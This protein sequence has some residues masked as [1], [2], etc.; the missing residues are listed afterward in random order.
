MMKIYDISGNVLFNDVPL[1]SASELVQELMTADY[2]RLSWR[3]AEN[4][5]IPAGSYI[6]I[7]DERYTLL[8][9]YSPTQK[10]EG[11][12]EYTPEFKSPFFLNSK[13]PFFLYKTVGG[14]TYKEAEWSLT[15]LP[16]NFLAILCTT[17][18]NETGQKYTYAIGAD[19]AV[20]SATLAFNCTDIISAI[21]QIANAFETE[22]WLEKYDTPDNSG[23][24]GCLHLSR[25]QLDY[26]PVASRLRDSW[27]KFV[28]THTNHDKIIVS[29]GV[30]ESYVDSD[31]DS[32]ILEV[33]NN[34][35]VPTINQVLDYYNRFYVFGSSRN[36]PQDY[37]GAATNN[38]AVK[39]LTLNP[40]D[41]P[42]GYMDFSNG[43]PVFTKILQFDDIYP[44]AT[45]L[46][47]KDIIVRQRYRLDDENKKIQ[48]GTDE[49]GDPMYDIYNVYY[50][51]LKIYDEGSYT[52]FTFN[53]TDYDKDDN[54]TG[55]LLPG[56]PV[57]FHFTEGPLNGREFE[58][59]YHETA[60]SQPVQDPADVS[61]FSWR[62]GD[63]EIN[64]IEEGEF[65]IP[66]LTG[67]VPQE[68]NHLI[69]FN[70]HM[71]DEYIEDA[72]DRLEQAALD[73]INKNYLDTDT[74]EP[75]DNNTYT[76][77][78]DPTVFY[79]ADPSLVVGNKVLYKNGDYEK[80]TRITAIR[81]RLD[82]P[83]YQ[84]LTF[85]DEVKKGSIQQLKEE[86]VSTNKDIDLLK[87]I[88][89]STAEIT[90]AYERTHQLILKQMA[91]NVQHAEY[92]DE[93]GNAQK[94][95]NHIFSDYLNQAVKTSSEVAFAKVTAPD[96][97]SANFSSGNLG[98][99]FRLWLDQ[100]NDGELEL[101]RLI[102]RKVMKVY[103]LIIQQ[104]KFQGG[105]YIYSVG[106]IV[107]TEVEELANDG[108]YKCYFDTKEGQEPNPFVVGDQARC[109]RFN[110]GTT[111][112]KY[113]WRL[114]T[115]V[116][117]DYIVLSKTDK[118][119]DSG[120]PE[121]GDNIVQ[122]GHRSTASR[123]KGIVLT[124]IDSNA[125]RMDFYDDIDSYDL[126]GCLITTIG[127]KNG[128]VGVYTENGSFT[129]VVNVTGG[130][131]K[132]L[133]DGISLD[134]Q[135]TTITGGMVLSSFIGVKDTNNH[136]RAA[137]NAS[138]TLAP[139][140]P[141]SA[142][143]GTSADHGRL[144]IAAGIGATQADWEAAYTTAKTRIFEDGTLITNAL[145]A[146][147][148]RIARF[149]IT[150]DGLGYGSLSET[151]Y[152]F[153]TPW[154]IHLNGTANDG[155][156]IGNARDVE[157]NVSDTLESF[158]QSE[159]NDLIS[160]TSKYRK[161][162]LLH[163]NFDTTQTLTGA[164]IKVDNGEF[165]GLRPYTLYLSGYDG[166][167]VG[168][169]QYVFQ[170]I[171]NDTYAR[172]ILP[173]SPKNGQTLFIYRVASGGSG[174]YIKSTDK[175]IWSSSGYTA[176]NTYGYWGTGYALVLLCYTKDGDS[177]SGCWISKSP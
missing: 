85:G 158:Y 126:S 172:L 25:A 122:F 6:L 24:I 59:T 10:T 39:R 51:Q 164:A 69:L 128:E 46:V 104:M 101:D 67:L 88:S 97:R 98:A 146:G 114:V 166:Q 123:K 47:I 137:I 138:S 58:V 117:T 66:A 13:V 153:I 30:D 131:V 142:Q 169:G 11:E 78:S 112:A 141:S 8:D 127:V 62:A 57:S 167:E 49:H 133:L 134:E 41:Y 44:S 63:F 5:I 9:P 115:A 95:D 1:T 70:V 71:P 150:T 99:G 171:Q 130:N 168:I 174:L 143:A 121:A 124:T 68:G 161:D 100:N 83:C 87:A 40:D 110:L 93:A 155:R 14:H 74:G 23:N 37:Q 18:Y 75:V 4:T 149:T 15:D 73:E 76:A 176:V 140:N 144:M 94:W 116:G 50:G 17:I 108:G 96:F 92:A 29:E 38:N 55:M 91:A 42:D 160:I 159:P 119:T 125:P 81:R 129:G 53:N 45:K 89:K 118:D 165:W 12:W 156:A 26:A 72:Y 16:S 84:T 154:D 90:A 56:L 102:V 19:V 132:Y 79:N 152:T 77:Q 111:T 163:L 86:A 34:I 82:L 31:T 136:I 3:S 80:E 43:G 20:A 2:A 64:W 105:M 170:V 103:E 22:L 32:L 33:G 48:I 173:S 120:V 148:G 35:K 28:V 145:V 147:A 61:P 113:Y 60:P 52:D 7:G 106:G 21:S 107:C 135:T 109:Q 36:I 54:P 177:G 65:I 175:R 157:L 27:S 139:F 151:Q 162:T